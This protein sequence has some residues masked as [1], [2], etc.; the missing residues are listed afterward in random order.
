M[1]LS[2]TCPRPQ[3][4]LH[5]DQWRV[6]HSSLCKNLLLH[7][8]FKHSIH[9]QPWCACAR[10]DAVEDT[11]RGEGRDRVLVRRLVHC[12][13]YCIYIILYSVISSGRAQLAAMLKPSEKSPRSDLFGGHAN[14][15]ELLKAMLRDHSA[16]SQASVPY[17]YSGHLCR[18]WRQQYACWVKACSNGA[19]KY[20][21]AAKRVFSKSLCLKGLRGLADFKINMS[22]CW[23]SLWHWAHK[24]SPQSS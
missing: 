15:T 14:A 12:H 24:L 5:D 16:L 19:V 21:S 1:H 9:D 8:Y 7:K 10:R 4:R 18:R 17:V 13:C 23:L 6:S 2:S 11:A 3:G 22:C 20:Y